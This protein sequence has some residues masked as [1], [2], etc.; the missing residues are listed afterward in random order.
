MVWSHCRIVIKRVPLLLHVGF[1]FWNTFYEKME[2][3]K[4]NDRVILNVGGVRHETYKTTL[5]KIPATRL[6]RL[7]KALVNYD[8]VLN[9]Y[10]YDRHPGVFA[11]V[12]NYYRTGK[13]HYPTDVCGPLFEEELEFWGLDSNQVEP[14]CWS[15]YSIHRDTQATLAILDKLDIESEKLSGEEIARLLGFEEDYHRGT[16]TRWQKLRSR[17]W[18]LF[19]EP[20]L[21][22]TAKCIACVS[23]FFICLSV[24]CFCAKNQTPVEP[25][26]NKRDYENHSDNSETAGPHRAFF[27]LEHAC[28]AWFTVEIVLRSLVSPSL[29]RFAMSPVNA[30]DLV[31][32]MSFYTEFLAEPNLY[33]ELLSIARVLRLFKLTRHSPGFRILIHTFKASAKELALLV[34][35]LVLGIVLFASLIFYAERLQENPHNDFDS[36][37][38][39]LWWALVT[40]T[41]VGYGDMTPKTFPGMFIGGLC[42]LAGVLTIALPV[43]VIVSNFSMFYSHTQA[44]SKLPKQRRRVLP[45]TPRRTRSLYHSYVD[46]KD[47]QFLADSTSKSIVGL[48][49]P[50][51]KK[52][53]TFYVTYNILRLTISKHSNKSAR[54]TCE[55]NYK[56][57][58]HGRFSTE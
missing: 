10:F 50:S 26:N 28:N 18:V 57:G 45:V 23:V 37:P 7:T 6:S 5:K 55:G 53:Y 19:D 52:I 1:S 29:R 34:F 24:L 41:T 27:Y 8:P 3:G 14:C 35:F 40:M 31:A 56:I 13:L 33:L 4:W 54:S 25:S 15:T 58:K 48:T 51:I 9:E 17:I 22:S 11:Q 20:Y 32:T 21:S 44:R 46:S 42:A 43:P 16:L 39:G 38:R 47:H 30:I 49:A 2:D 36:I 12:L